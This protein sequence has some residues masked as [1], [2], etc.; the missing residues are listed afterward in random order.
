MFGKKISLLI[1]LST[2]FYTSFSQ[3]QCGTAAEGG[4]VTL[5]APLGYVFTS[6]TFASYGTPNGSCGSF[7]IGGCHAANSKTIVEGLLLGNNSAS[8]G[9]NNGIFGDPCGGT[10]KRLYIEAVYSLALPLKLVS[11]S[12]TAY[13][14]VNKLSWQ[15]TDEI[16][17]KVFLIERSNDGIH[18]STIGTVAAANQH[19]NNNYSYSDDKL[20]GSVQFYR[21]KMM[22][23]DGKSQYGN[24]IK[25]QSSSV[26][27]FTVF[28]NPVTNSVTLNGLHSKGQI[29]ISD[30]QGRVIKKVTVIAQTQTINLENYSKGMYIIGYRY[31][32]NFIC[33][34]LLKE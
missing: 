17:T 30:I 26:S 15:T 16:N 32:N 21:L 9:A 6:V 22:D 23:I 29:E 33:E 1:F 19:G 12:G 4:T 7:T 2:T 11:F 34:K 13:A 27:R 20:Q 8:I 25:L 10:F 28:P 3:S 18:F 14:S 24:I 5:T 31:D